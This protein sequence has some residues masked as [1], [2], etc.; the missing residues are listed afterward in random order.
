MVAPQNEEILRILDFIG[1]QETN[2]L[3]G[4]LATVDVIAQKEVVG[5]RR[6][7]AVLK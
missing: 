6:E 5:L 4:L 2:G 7:A 1:K 3:Q